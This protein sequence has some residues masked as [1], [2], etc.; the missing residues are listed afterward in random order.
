MRVIERTPLE[1]VGEVELGLLTSDAPLLIDG[2]LEELAASGVGRGTAMADEA[3]ERARGLDRLRRGDQAAIEIPRDLA[4]L[5]SLLIESLRRDVPEQRPGDFA[6]AVERLA[7][8]FGS[9]QASVTDSLVRERAGD[10]RR[11]ELTGLPGYAE[12]HEWLQILLAEQRRYDHPFAVSLVDIDGLARINDAYGRRAGDKMLTTLATVIR[13]HTRD[14]DQVFR[15]GDDEFCVLS[16]HA[17]IAQAKPAAKRL[18]SVIE[19]SQAE[20]GPRIAISVGVASC[21]ESGDQTDQLM[22]AAEQ[23]T[24]A[25]KASAQ[26]VAVA[27][28]A[29][30]AVQDR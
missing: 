27:N 19:A 10:A 29:G 14:V 22:R 8:I 23:A 9:I 1:E 26:P 17:A 7:E 4:A 3:A 18:A 28:S 24:Y 6:R 16:P 25:A 5:Q 30:V 21:P 13:S 15:F 2:I 20:S 12:F 11:D